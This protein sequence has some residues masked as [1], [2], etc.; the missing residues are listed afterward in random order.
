MDVP[1]P[2]IFELLAMLTRY[3]KRQQDL[4]ESVHADPLPK[5]LHTSG[6]RKNNLGTDMLLNADDTRVFMSKSSRMAKHSSKDTGPHKVSGT[7][8]RSPN[9]LTVTAA[10][11]ASPRTEDTSK[12]KVR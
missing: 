3:M 1:D 9:D 11:K 7:I 2:S 12:D 4:R 10:W 6:S 5:V 8:E